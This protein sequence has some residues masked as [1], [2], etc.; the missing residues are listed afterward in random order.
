[1]G[2][3]IDFDLVSVNKT[4]NSIKVIGEVIEWYKWLW[5]ASDESS[6]LKSLSW[7][8]SSKLMALGV[9][10]IDVLGVFIQPLC[11][12]VPVFNGSHL[13]DMEIGLNNQ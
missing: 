7:M 4:S 12:R 1:M 10:Q 3:D 9:H 2:D 11:P 6:S 8:N 5:F 13:T